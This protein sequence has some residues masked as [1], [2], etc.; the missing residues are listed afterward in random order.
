MVDKMSKLELAS[1]WLEVSFPKIVP[2]EN[3]F[4]MTFEI[5]GN[6]FLVKF[7]TKSRKKG[8]ILISD[9]RFCLSTS[10]LNGSKQ[11]LF[12]KKRQ[13]LFASDFVAT[14]SKIFCH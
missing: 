6:L 5:L 8:R 2:F 14:F 13:V 12:L 11:L 10:L 4:A 1:I 3:M 9:V 7:F